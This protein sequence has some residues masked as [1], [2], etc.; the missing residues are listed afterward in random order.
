MFN[1]IRKLLNKEKK[2]IYKYLDDLSKL[3]FYEL[4]EA[5]PELFH[6]NIL[7]DIRRDL[8]ERHW[9]KKVI[10]QLQY[11]IKYIRDSKLLNK[12]AIDI[13]KA[14]QAMTPIAVSRTSANQRFILIPNF[15]TSQ[16][17]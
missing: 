11:K 1:G 5:D 7:N 13:Q 10:E 12:K 16:N 15:L 9:E 14:H 4:Y 6:E 17:Y 2:P 3:T 8:I